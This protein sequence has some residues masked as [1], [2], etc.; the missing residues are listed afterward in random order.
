MINPV[1]LGMHYHMLLK[2]LS[3]TYVVFTAHIHRLSGIILMATI[4]IFQ[5]FSKI[6]K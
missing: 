2:S 1:L 6:F 5:F 4:H 3:M